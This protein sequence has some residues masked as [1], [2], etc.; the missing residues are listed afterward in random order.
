MSGKYRS[1][2]PFLAARDLHRTLAFYRDVLDFECELLFPDPPRPPSLLVL[3]KDEA[4]IMFESGLWHDLNGGVPLLTGALRFDLAKVPGFGIGD[5]LTGGKRESTV[6][7]VHNKVKAAGAPVLWG[8]EV[9][10][11]GRREFSCTDPDGYTL[12]FSEET[13]E[14]ATDAD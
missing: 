1:I 12:I 4:T 2:T 9:Y 3:R 11:Y 6:M 5:L 14:P 7:A 13:D 8:P 10:F